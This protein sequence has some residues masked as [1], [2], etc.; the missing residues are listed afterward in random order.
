METSLSLNAFQN[1]AH[2][3][4]TLIY[5]FLAG[6]M[7]KRDNPGVTGSAGFVSKWIRR[8]RIGLI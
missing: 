1:P 4:S 8:L 5:L 7:N 2:L 6:I 3:T